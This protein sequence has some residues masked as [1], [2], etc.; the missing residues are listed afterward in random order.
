MTAKEYLSQLRTLDEKIRCQAA[1]AA[2]LRDA[3]TTITQS[4]KE[5][6]THGGGR[7]DRTAETVAR[8]LDL[9]AEIS[10]EVE[11]LTTLK[12]D[13]SG[14]LDSIQN[15]NFYVVLYRRYV[16]FETFEQIACEMGCTWRNTC[17]IHGKALQAFA[18]VMDAEQVL[19]GATINDGNEGTA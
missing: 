7:K 12:R 8:L 3:T 10:R 11:R 9:E 14:K 2:R 17:Y 16:L 15:R 19:G 4:L 6:A 1:D 5:D 13:I 18:K